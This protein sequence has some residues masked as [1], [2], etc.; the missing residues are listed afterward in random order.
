MLE[1]IAGWLADIESEEHLADKLMGLLK[2]NSD[3][4]SSVQSRLSQELDGEDGHRLSEQLR[5]FDAQLY[6]IGSI[7]ADADA[8]LDKAE[9]YYLIQQGRSVPCTTSDGTVVPAT[10]CRVKPGHDDFLPK[11]K[12]LTDVDRNTHLAS[13]VAPFRRLRNEFAVMAK[14]IESRMWLGKMILGELQARHK[15]SG[16]V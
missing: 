13:K 4:I 11:Y 5:W 6:F 3:R 12:E 7:Q 8:L 14:A 1:D 16:I 15:A 9:K 10:G 2:R